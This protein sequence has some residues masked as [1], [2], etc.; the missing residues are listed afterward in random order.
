M[1]F[2]K[3][4]HQLK[5]DSELAFYPSEEIH[6]TCISPLIEVIPHD[7]MTGTMLYDLSE[8]HGRSTPKLCFLGA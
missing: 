4:E 3:T 1:T 6:S 5:T 8:L 2:S 7:V